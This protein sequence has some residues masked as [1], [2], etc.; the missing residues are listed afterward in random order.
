MLKLICTTVTPPPTIIVG[1]GIVPAVIE[2][3]LHM[4]KT[5]NSANAVSPESLIVS[6]SVFAPT[7]EPSVTRIWTKPPD[8]ITPEGAGCSDPVV[9]SVIPVGGSF[10]PQLVKNVGTV[11]LVDKPT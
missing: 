4:M 1:D 2:L 8:M 11:K 10:V 5:R 6:L 7:R 9:Q 3:I